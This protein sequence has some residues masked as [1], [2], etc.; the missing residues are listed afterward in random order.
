MILAPL[1]VIMVEVVPAPRRVIPL[2]N[3]TP[4][5]HEQEPDGTFT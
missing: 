4:D 1:P 3:V 5:V 2:F